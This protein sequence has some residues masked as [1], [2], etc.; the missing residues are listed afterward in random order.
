MPI[1]YYFTPL[2]VPDLKKNLYLQTRFLRRFGF[3]SFLICGSL[4]SS[5]GQTTYYVASSGSDNNSGRSADSPF[6]TLN[7]VNS[8]TLQPGD[9]LLFRRGDTFRGSLVIRQSG[10]SGSPIVIDAYGSGN[11]PSI[12]GSVPVGN[13]TNT[14]NNVWQA[15]CPSCGSRVTGVYRNGTSLP[16]GRYP[17]L[18]DSNK[19]Y[20]TVQSHSGKSQLTSQ[21]SLSTN[22]T[23]GEVVVR[24]VQ[25]ILDRAPITQQ[26][27]NTL[28][29][30]NTNS[31]DLADGWG[32]FIQN[33]SATL[34]QT[35]EWYYNPANKTIRLFDSQSN[36][37]SQ[38]ITATAFSE[39]ISL[40]NVSNITIRNLQITQT[41]AT[42]LLV[43]GGSN[44]VFSGND[45]TNSGED[46]VYVNG[47]GSNV[48]AEN[49]L[50]ED[51]NS[52]GFFIQPYK[53]FT[54]RGN[55]IRRVGLIPG[56]GKSGDGSYSALQS[57]CT[58]NTLI[59]NNVIDNVG[60][61]GIAIV[62]KTTVRNNQVSNFC[63]TKS[64]GGGIY[65]WNGGRANVEDMHIL[66][67]IVF[68]GIGAPEGT[69]GGAYSG[70]NGI[71][72][73]DCSRNV[74]VVN[75]TSFNSRGMG[76]FL[77]GVTNITVKGNTSYN[78][79]E[80]QLKLAYN[81]NCAL[82]NNIVQNNILFSKQPDQVVVAYESNAN[83]LGSYGDFN[84]NYYVRPF[85]D[86]YKIRAVYNPGSGLTGADY[87]LTEWQ[88][89]YGK[90]AN[91]FN[92]PI[93]YKTQVVSQ[94]GASV[95]NN[96]FSGGSEGWSVWSPYGN[97][98]ADWDNA[99]RLDGG[100]LRL[101]FA[102]ASNQ[103][104]SY[105]L[106]TVNIGSVTK[107]KTY[108]LLFDGVASGSNK[109]LEVY[110]RRL[111]GN[112]QDLAVRASLSMSS[113]RQQYEATFTATSDES[114]AIL[115]IQVQEDGQTAW[116]DNLRL[117]EAT[118]SSQNPDNF[119][120]LVYNATGQNTTVSLDGSYRDVKNTQYNG[121]VT[122]APF[123]SVIL[124]KEVGTPATPTAPVVSL[125]NPENPANAVSGL[126]FSYYEGSWGNLPDFNSLTASK[127]GNVGTPDLSIRNRDSDY[128]VR[129]R[130]YVNVPTDGDYTFYVNSDDGSKLL[131]GTTEVVNNDGGHGPLEKSGTIGLKA[132]KH[133]LTVPFFQ[134]SGGQTLTVS[135]SGPG[136][137]KQAI[138][139]SAFF[140]VSMGS[141]NPVAGAG[142]GLAA[143]Y[144]TNKTLS[145]SSV[146]TRTDATVDF[147]WG[148]S[149]PA[150]GT[151]PNDNFSVRW[152]GQ[153]QAPVTGSY[154][155]STIS[156]DGIRLWVNG[157]QVINNWSDHGSTTDNS[158]SIA[159]T[160][161][162]K[163]D[164]KLEYYEN[165]AGAIAR[166]R[167]AYPG[168]GQQI[169]PTAQLY[170]ASVAAPA[171]APTTS[172]GTMYLSDMTWTN[173]TNGHGPAERDKS[174]GE[175]GAGDGR[176]ITLN[177]KT[178]AKGLGLH[179][180][181]EITYNLGGKY[182]TFISDIGI[183]DEVGEGCG[184]VE[185]QVYADN[186]AIYS[187]GVVTAATATKTVTLNVSGKQTL[188]L[189]ITTAGD[190]PYCD[191]ADWAGARVIGTGGGRLA[192]MTGGE[193]ASALTVQVYPIPAQ[194]EV[195][196]HYYAEVAGDVALELVNTAALPV[197]RITYPV[198]PGDNTI[199][200]PVRDLTRGFYILSLTQD[201]RRFTRKVI[202]SE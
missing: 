151:V 60:Y 201:R 195:Q 191:H 110:P 184:T 90:D 59:E 8:L 192:A 119:I 54:F 179:S 67:N 137:N 182:A 70:A 19:G 160:A 34:D 163:Y 43:N 3:V 104:N 185:F 83:D 152:S 122:V 177:G 10:S 200:V 189:V 157:T 194:D 29:L 100:S 15:D 77:R 86:L 17:N 141:S 14:G 108:Q 183:D 187:S 130:G 78:N 147:D 58:N 190:N 7:K 81:G 31:Y 22:W 12:A 39:G 180:P 28:T 170:P 47:S 107:G 114:N 112:Y 84:Y 167:W 98:R 33:H 73:D 135:Y 145:G 74:E 139:A 94:T 171:P 93:T 196:V 202:L 53:D 168:Q 186:V 1:S 49:N 38:L 116:I 161:G 66:S 178:Y 144:F 18:S 197:R 118:L 155:F 25:W 138:P 36:P 71:F 169:I 32:Y 99:N 40:P 27:G 65:S 82:R 62:T 126:D 9:N 91:S 35:G 106:A 146:L 133:A 46:A 158:Q 6:Q 63:L 199:R 124:M 50:I 109:R 64:D 172:G 51:A 55:T 174:N 4:V 97:G 76:I 42:G 127:T 136:I 131:I 148:T 142:T 11:K 193:D 13:W 75:N 88:G 143:E 102:S 125:R 162:Q 45:I 48:L 61:N 154:T 72:M 173:M 5:S 26:N 23:G 44:L 132:G 41:I 20:L 128:G 150:A 30:N 181:S 166:L 56:R 159:L 121:S 69:P 198:V 123:S 95:L 113:S 164:I 149:S 52:N 96:S 134:G 92:S 57:L 24:P 101:A 175:S 103:G 188:R 85:A 2:L 117:R 165:V 68:N 129:F 37:N 80:E 21:Q 111:S 153:V 105:L 16:L 140:R 176:T 87:S 79:A 115:V 120:K 156:D 89:R